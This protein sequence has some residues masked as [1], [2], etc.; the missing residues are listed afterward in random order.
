MRLDSAPS[1]PS[2]VQWRSQPSPQRR[3]C[4]ASTRI[5]S[6]GDGNAASL[7]LLF[8]G[9]GPCNTVAPPAWLPRVSPAPRFLGSASGPTYLPEFADS[10]GCPAPL[11]HSL[12]APAASCAVARVGSA[13]PERARAQGRPA[14]ASRPAGP[15]ASG[16]A[17]RE[18]RA[19]RSSGRSTRGT[20]STEPGGRRRSADSPLPAA[21]VLHVLACAPVL[22]AR[23]ACA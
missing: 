16:S 2:S 9:G 12:P 7:A 1:R 13:T 18:A 14:S 5:T 8:C 23:N 3:E 21:S 15:R 11:G 17:R 10:S 4:L 20:R 6:A 22:C 19:P